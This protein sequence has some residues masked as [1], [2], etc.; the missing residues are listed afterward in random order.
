MAQGRNVRVEDFPVLEKDGDLDSF[1]TAFERT[2]LQHHLDKEQW[3]KY[4]TPRLRGKALDI[5]GDLP[6]EA[7][8][9]YDTI[10][11]ALIQ[12]Y[13]L[14]PESYRKKFRS[15]QKGPKDSWGAGRGVREVGVTDRIPAN[16]LLGTDLGQITSQFG[17]PPRAE[18]SAH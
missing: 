2:C 5:L 4:L 6:A 13:N 17:P 11:R 1:L 9:G 3:A 8:Q 16:V 15:L 10:K 14:T 12:Q 7:D 18:P